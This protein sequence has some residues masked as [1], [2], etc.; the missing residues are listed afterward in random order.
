MTDPFPPD[1]HNI[2]NP[3]P[4]ELGT[5]NC[6]TMATTP[7][8][9]HDTC[10]VL[11]VTCQVSG[12]TCQVSHVTCNSQTVRGRKLKFLE[13]VHLPIPVT[14]Q[15]SHVMRHMSHVTCNLLFFFGQCGETSHEG[16]VINGATHSSLLVY[17]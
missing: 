16:S 10:H 4:S 7:C 15:V 14:C 8:V 2:I 9:S 12:V 11:R 3:K 17:N 6:D 5:S 1:I 13:K